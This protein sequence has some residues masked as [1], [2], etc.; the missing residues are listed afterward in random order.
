M[1]VCIIFGGGNITAPY[2]NDTW[3]Y[4]FNYHKDS[5]I[6]ISHTI[7]AGAPARFG[8]IEWDASLPNL[9]S[10][11]A[12]LRSAETEAGLAEKPFIGPDGSPQS[13][14]NTSGQ[15][16]F[17]GH[18]G[19]RWIQYRLELRTQDIMRSP[20]VRSVRINC[21][22]IHNLTL[23][24]P[25]GGENLTGLQTIEWEAQDPDND[26]LAFDIYYHR[27]IVSGPLALNLSN[28]TRSWLWNTSELPSGNYR[29][30][31]VA[32]DVNTSIPV[33]VEA[34]SEVFALKHPPPPPPNSPPEV[35]LVSPPDGSR[36]SDTYV[37]LEWA[38]RDAEG[39]ALR[40]SVFL[41][42]EAFTSGSLP[43]PRTT[44]ALT[45]YGPLN[46]QPGATYY[47]TVVAS[48]GRESSAV[49][50]PWR[51]TILLPGQ[52][53]A[54]EVQLLSP[55]DGSIINTTNV[56][57]SWSGTDPDGDRLA[58]SLFLCSTIFD[59]LSL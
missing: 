11:R 58:F 5:G 40:Y 27:G 29:I 22:L 17:S 59:A 7:D 2:N 14:Y 54:P 23:K 6:F 39:D 45:S 30:R 12:Q 44:T 10:V 52:N 38:G 26:T 18:N 56:T 19:S 9:T 41:S 28:D 24:F 50:G 47:W 49:P 36:L 1:N 43:S 8:T 46:L 25:A 31:V 15:T 32:R 35:E 21:N 33:A 55:T 20:I 51:F 3:V 53:T 34:I 48:D 4:T 57:L 37:T 16:I 13:Y 42:E